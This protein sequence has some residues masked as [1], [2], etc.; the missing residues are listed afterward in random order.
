MRTIGAVS[1]QVARHFPKSNPGQT[2]RHQLPFAR[3][4]PSLRASG[5]L[6]GFVPAG[7]I[8]LDREQRRNVAHPFYANGDRAPAT[9]EATGID[10]L[11]R[12]V[13]YNDGEGA[14]SRLDDPSEGGDM[15]YHRSPRDA[16]TVRDLLLA[17][18]A[19]VVEPRR[20]D[21]R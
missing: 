10:T 19:D 3:G 14:R 5:H 13:H 7:T 11:L 9:F 18:S 16:Q 15:A 6:T 20:F 4:K 17:H 8:K 21:G 2:I 1:W 12:A